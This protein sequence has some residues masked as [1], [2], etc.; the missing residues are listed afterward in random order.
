MKRKQTIKLFGLLTCAVFSSSGAVFA[1]EAQ[2]MSMVRSMQ[3]E[4]QDMKST[5]QQQNQQIQALQSQRAAAV[6]PSAGTP[7]QAA[8]FS[9]G[10][11]DN[12]L[13]K[14][15]GKD[16]KWLKDLKF[17][18]DMR[19][20]YEARN[21]SRS[22][23]RDRN[24]FRFRLRYGF[25]KK[26]SDE[27]KVGF[28]MVSADAA[29]ATGERTSTNATLS[30]DF[31]YKTIGIDRAYATYTPNWGRSY[32]VEVTG[33]KF[34]NPFELGSSKIVWDP[35]VTPEGAYQ[36]I[37]P[38]LIAGET[39]DV[40]MP[41]TVGEF[42]LTEGAAGEHADSELYAIQ[43]GLTTS[44]RNITEKPIETSHLV[45]FYGYRDF[46]SNSNFASAGGAP[47]V[48]GGTRLAAEQY[49]IFEVYNDVAFQTMGLP[50]SKLFFDWVT[51][52]GNNAPSDLLGKDQSSAFNAGLQL[53]Q[54]KKKRDWMLAAEYR[55]IGE[56][57][58][59][60]VF[61]D[62]DFG[63]GGVNKRGPVFSLGYG[64]TNYLQLNFSAFLANVIEGRKNDADLYT[65]QLDMVWNF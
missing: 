28:R 5:I 9:Q 37:N 24:R 45:S 57:S 44:L 10:D 42:I 30:N 54:V 1:D 55:Y 51:N 53:G 21:Q 15:L 23:A 32:G 25:E 17:K 62:S 14:A 64:L 65:Y 22:G 49:R 26:F 19:L 59:P 34:Q 13:E 56:N 7:A 39:F 8:S 6:E 40:S 41:I 58:V 33:G 43:G 63:G 46:A 31:G 18:G 60:G 36:R 4:M 50:K 47:T 61:N 29:S 52:F 48:S 3:Q 11:F 20:R 38:G 35:D 2:L 27:W 12:A 16:Y